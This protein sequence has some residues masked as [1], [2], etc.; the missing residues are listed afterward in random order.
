MTDLLVP[1]VHALEP[2]DRVRAWLRLAEGGSITTM[3]DTDDY[4][5]LALAGSEGDRP[6][7]AYV[8][9][10]KSHGI[11]ASVRGVRAAEDWALEAL[12]SAA[13]VGPELE[14]LAL[15]GLAW[16]RALRGQPIDDVCERF[17]AASD[18]AAH[19]ADSPEPVAGLR[20]LWR[21]QIEEARAVLNRF[22]ALADA[23]GEEVSY[24]LQRLNVCDLEL[25]AGNWDA[26]ARLLD[27]WKSADRQLLITA[28]YERSLALLA[29]GRGHSDEAERLATSAYSSAEPAGYGWQELESLRARGT[30]ALLDGRPDRAARSLRAAWEHT[31]REGVDEPGA[32]P[33]APELVEALV[34]L[35]ELDEARTVI[36]R[37]RRLAE[38]QEHPWGLA[39]TKRCDALVRLTAG[40]YDAQTEADL[41]AAADAYGSLG[42]R[43][44]R[45][46][47]LLSLGRAQRRLR[48]WGAARDSLD[49]AAAEFD[50]LGSPGWAEQARTELA[51]VG[52]RRPRDEGGLTPTER[53]VAELAADGLANKEIAHALHVTVRT[54]EV[55]LKNA[56]AKL[57]IR[58]RT[59][60]ARRLS[61][62]G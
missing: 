33:I 10:K 35:G 46:R 31:E 42:L 7:R 24:A 19:I 2:R 59:Q 25:R 28:T 55:H 61:E 44:E 43:F 47:T 56:Y 53:R 45:P 6:L 26:A 21:G 27:E 62:P 38:E 13:K 15:H 32:F 11:A 1:D 30:A 5:D 22:L 4:L 18:A 51:R 39:T 54:V 37:L 16:A 3:H 34:E 8:L 9:A 60:L 58:S 36:A 23:R 48:K 49:L 12:P 29:C 57:R 17:R 20:L 40:G 52:G 50:A 14:R 41:A